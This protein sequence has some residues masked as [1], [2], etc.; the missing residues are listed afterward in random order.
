MSHEMSA[1]TA[2]SANGAVDLSNCAR[3][4]IHIPGKIQPH[5]L[6]LV[7]E[8]AALIV[9][10]VS[11]NSAELVGIPPG[12][13][14][15]RRLEEL[16][17]DDQ[18]AHLRMI[19]RGD[20]LIRAN[21]LKLR[22]PDRAA[23]REFNVLVHGIDGE[24]VLE[25]EP[26]EDQDVGDFQSFYHEVR[27]ATARLQ[28][29]E[30]EETLCQVAADE[31]RRII[32]YDRVM[33]YRFDADWNGMVI[34]ESQDDQLASSYLGLHFPASDIPA[35]ARRLYTVNTLRCIPDAGYRPV[36]LVDGDTAG[37]GRPLDMSHCVLRSVSPMHLEYLRIMGVGATRSVSLMKNG[38]LWGLIACHHY[39]PRRV[40]R[41]RRL[42]CSFLG[43]IIE[44][45]LNM[46]EDGAER[47][48]RVQTAAIQ[49]RFLNAFSRGACL[50]GLATDPASVL[51]FVDAQGAAIVQG[52][53]GTLV[54]RTPDHA[55]IPGLIDMMSASLDRGVY[56]TDS[57]SATYPPAARFKDVA[58]GMLGVEISR[59][60]G[61]YLLWFR[62]EQVRLVNWAGNPDLHHVLRVSRYRRRSARG[63]TVR[64]PTA[65]RSSGR[66]ERHRGHPARPRRGRWRP[67]RLR[68]PVAPV[69]PGGRP[70]PPA[71][72]RRPCRTS[73]N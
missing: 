54:G 43:Q 72:R 66:C 3:E 65:I 42:T 12:E 26:I 62:P 1:D 11:A 55:E 8:E 41:D 29:N 61:D 16:L 17:G 2:S 59:E 63:G 28:A 56:S 48:Y 36:G 46:R 23:G 67:D 27:R 19:L 40:C 49:V 10:R 31:V 58:S 53:K 22:L 68:P 13:L 32:G 21:P 7:L 24:L 50:S 60:R 30:S 71:R 25:A 45:Q 39:Q 69:R 9:R 15:D 34:E 20:D 44:S 52:M 38:E 35:Q 4:P 14:L 6:L 57:L 73:R 37:R 18:C 5:G 64:R 70:F 47:A 33:V 51:D